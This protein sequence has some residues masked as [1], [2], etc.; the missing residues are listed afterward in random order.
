MAMTSH[1][2]RAL[3]PHGFHRVHYTE[4]GEPEIRR[5]WSASTV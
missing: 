4:W 2:Y 3:G 5:C 1:Y